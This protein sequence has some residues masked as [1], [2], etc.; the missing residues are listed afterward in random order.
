[1]CLSAG[2]DPSSDKA[3]QSQTEA[4][5][6]FFGDKVACFSLTEPEIRTLAKNTVRITAQGETERPTLTVIDFGE[7]QEPQNF[8]DTFLS[9]GH[10]NKTKIKFA[11]GVYNQGGSATLKFCSGGYQLIVS[12]RCPNIPK[13]KSEAWG[14]TLVRERYEQGSKAE[15]YEYC[16]VKEKEGYVIPSIPFESLQ[17]LPDGQFLDYGSVVRLYS[18]YLKNANQFITGQLEKQLARE[19]NKK[20]FSMPLPIELDEMRS[21]LS[22]WAKKNEKTRIFGQWKLL[23]KQLAEKDFIRKKL[24]LKGELGVFGLRDIEVVIL[25]DESERGKT[26]KNQQEKVFLTVNGQAQHT[27][28]VNFLKTDC[29]LPDLAPFMIVHVD[30]SNANYQAN[31]VFQTARSGVIAIP[32]YDVF[33]QKLIKA[34]KDDEIIIGLDQDYRERKLKNA[35]PED[36]DLSKFIEKLVKGNS[37]FLPYF[38]IGMD[39]SSEKPIGDSQDYTGEYIPTSIEVLGEDNKLIPINRYAWV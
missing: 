32:E 33:R 34:I 38:Q 30:L 19:I 10:S 29:L 11:H 22:G 25:N 28:T 37:A 17:I 15:Q 5:K 12:R 8:P 16:L 14:F 6:M 20:Y 1:M 36:K 13:A 4:I 18:Y 31:K 7:G 21:S 9:I 23:K 39:I 2:I 24:L 26:Y 35:Q 27:E 3:P